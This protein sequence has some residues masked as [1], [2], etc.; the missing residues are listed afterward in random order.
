MDA[1]DQHLVN[2]A[3]KELPND[4]YAG[5]GPRLGATLL[6]G[7]VLI[8]VTVLVI[9]NL[10]T[11]K[12][13]E[14]FLALTVINI[15]YKP[16]FEYKFGATLGKMAAGTKVTNL[17][18]GAINLQEAL[19]R[20]I[21]HIIFVFISAGSTLWIMDQPGFEYVDTFFDYSAFMQSHNQ[22]SLITTWVPA[23]T[24]LA[25]GIVMLSDTQKRSLH[26]MIGK[27]YVMRKQYLNTGT[28]PAL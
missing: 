22:Y 8:P 18:F 20:N 10:F 17:D 16:F 12:S 27:T 25:D 4:A 2:D 23:L 21:F 24:T 5:F 1:L 11:W 28:S 26:D 15:G 13:M 6:D 19:M 14:L 3:R 9:V 7:L